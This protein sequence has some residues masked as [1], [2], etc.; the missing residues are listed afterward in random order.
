MEIENYH[1]CVGVMGGGHLTASRKVWFQKFHNEPFTE[2]IKTHSQVFFVMYGQLFVFRSYKWKSTLNRSKELKKIIVF[3]NW[4]NEFSKRFWQK[5]SLFTEHVFGTNLW[6]KLSFFT[7]PTIFF[8]KRTKSSFFERLKILFKI[9][10]IFRR[11]DLTPT[12]I[13]QGLNKKDYKI[14]IKF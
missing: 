13:G 1:I 5:L 2:E 11:M 7:E 10:S 8:N 12:D 9:A 3:F 14:N 4:T 6:K